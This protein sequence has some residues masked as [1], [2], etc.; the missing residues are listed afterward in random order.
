MLALP[1]STGT[2]AINL[3]AL[4]PTQ[5]RTTMTCLPQDLSQSQLAALAILPEAVPD[6]LSKLSPSTP[7]NIPKLSSYLCDHPDPVAVHT[8]LTGFSQGFKIGYQGPRIPK[9]YSNLRSAKDNLSIISKNILKEVQLGHTAG[10]FTSPPFSNLQVYPI[11]VIPKKNS[12]DWRT[13]FHLSYPKHHPTSVNAHIS[14][15]EYSLHYITV[16]NAVSI[17]QKLGQGCFMSKLD[18][19]S[20]FRNIPVHPS[21]WELL[22]MKWN[23]LYYFDTVLPFGLRSAP[24]L[25]D[26]FSCMIE[27]IIK[28]KL[29][30]PDVIHILDDFFFVTKPPRSNCL[31][32]LCNILCLFTELDVPIAPGKTFAPTTCLEFMGILLDSNKMEA[33]LPL[34]KLTRVKRPCSSG[35]IGN[36]LPSRNFS[37]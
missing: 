37:P 12:S 14:P 30:I 1:A 36:L 22:G 2:N 20:A 28:A 33:R 3:D 7:I 19:K 4:Q 15:D 9:E 6:Y 25:F 13:I 17:I 16:D 31:T 23:A 24:F 21:D 34:D 32:A 27:W 8:L 18:I 29:G 26:Q 11:G 10:P 35:L 5:E